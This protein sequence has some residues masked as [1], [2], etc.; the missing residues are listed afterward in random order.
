MPDRNWGFILVALVG[1]I[2]YVFSVGVGVR[3][4]AHYPEAYP[5]YQEAPGNVAGAET[6][7]RLDVQPV[8][9]KHPCREPQGHDES[10]LCAQYRAAEAAGIAAYWA[11][12]QAWLSLAGIVGLSFTVF[13]TIRATNAAVDANKIASETKEETIRIGEAQTRAY[14]SVVRA[15]VHVDRKDRNHPNF[16]RFEVALHFH[17]SGETPAVN[18]AYHCTAEVSKWIDVNILPSL[19]TVPEQRFVTNIPPGE[20]SEIDVPCYGIA[21]RWREYKE[22]WDQVT[23]DTKFGQMPMLVIYGVVFYEDVF[24]QTFRS[25]FAFWFGKKPKTDGPTGRDD[26]DTLQACIPTFERISDRQKYIIPES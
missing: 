17:N 21:L 5:A 22:Q 7:A 16:P 9:Y 14:L 25:Q 26:L 8:R 18:V 15:D 11:R 20:A 13:L 6:T 3:E 2:L 19:G 1:L 24:G 4:L 12:W 10:D 23:E